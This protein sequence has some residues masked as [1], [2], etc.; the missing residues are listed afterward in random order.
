M[1][2][3]TLSTLKSGAGRFAR[4]QPADTVKALATRTLYTVATEPFY[5]LP[6]RTPRECTHEEAVQLI[7]SGSNVFIHSAAATPEDLVIAMT[8]HAKG[9]QL[10]DITTYSIHTEVLLTANG[11]SALIAMLILLLLQG[12]APYTDEDCVGIFQ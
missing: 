10:K 7:T 12:K 5:P 1:L 4:A 9:E 6:G 3:R 11:L 2:S 8:E